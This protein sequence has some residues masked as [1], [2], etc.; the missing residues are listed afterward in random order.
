MAK[1]IGQIFEESDYSRF[2]RLPDNRDVLERRLGK[3]IASVSEKYVL[4]PI[5][6]N[7]K[8]EIIDGQG[9]YEALKHL[10]RP[11]H[12]IIAHGA[13]SDDC[14]RMNKYNTRWDAL[15]FAKSFKKAGLEA[16][17]I[18]LRT[19]DNT[20]FPISLVLRMGG[21]GGANRQKKN[22]QNRMTPFEK[23][24]LVFTEE[25]AAAAERTISLAK[26]I[27]EALQFTAKPNHTFYTA[28]KVC[29][30]YEGYNHARMISNC[31]KNRSSYAQ[32]S[33]LEAQLKEFER[34][35]N[36]KARSNRL[37]FS[38]YMRKRGSNTRDYSDIYSPYTDT[39]ISSLVARERE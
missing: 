16:Y 4:N 2:H 6:V 15:D 19:C 28:V 29:S 35:Y 32:M 10:G 9:R 13:T 17:A 23:G 27:L 34:I 26:D 12:Y 33:G 38:D 18:L 36:Y 37:Y 24:D 7:E 1:V 21:H 14:R 30:D 22:G 31:Q 11:I 39:D 20:G 25:D 3:I 8:M 5:I